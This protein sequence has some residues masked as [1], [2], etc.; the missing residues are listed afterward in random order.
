[1]MKN[2]S[3]RRF[4][5]GVAALSASPA[6]AQ[7]AVQLPVAGEI[8]VL[9]VGAGAAGI[10][11]ARR[12]VAAGRTYT[13]FEAR[14]RIGGRVWTDRGAFGIAH[15]RGAHRI[16]ASGRN[17]LVALGRLGGVDFYEPAPF[18]RLYVGPREARDHE[19]D[20]F[21]AALHRAS[22]AIAAAGEAGLDLAAVRTLPELGD[23][24][25]TVAFVLGPLATSK[26]L[27]EVSTVDFARADEQ[28]DTLACRGGLG[29]LLAA[30]AKPL[31]IELDTA[32]TRIDARG[33][34]AVIVET[35]RGAMRAN[36]V[37]VTASTAAVLSGAIRFEP[38]L[39]K[40]TVDAFAGLTLGTHDR[41]IFELP[42]NPFQFRDDQR[43]VF[44]AGD[45]RTLSLV[46]RVGGSDLAY[47]E[48][49]GR[50]GREMSDAGDAA[51]VEFVGEQFAAHFG[52]DAKKRIARSQ[53]TRWSREPW[54]LGAASVAA[55]GSGGNRRILA[56]PAHER[57]FFAGEALHESWYGTVAGAWIAGERAADAAIRRLV[58]SAPPAARV[59]PQQKQ[60]AK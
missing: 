29:V 53:V 2:L 35:P 14:S 21:T 44:K 26:D 17:P 7:P 8:D 18:R 41:L 15:D 47:A 43:V 25:A 23:W 39:P 46:G 52:A 3:R 19:Y 54:I 13:L 5:T 36:A 40:R 10:A 56:E 6:F 22:R 58:A 51:M 27:E 9:I 24:R 55:P 37:I 34:G 20:S 48:F 32:V 30:A 45:T 12:V 38:A 59:G 57:I 49:V 4:L 42:G 50:F 28:R 11:A 1:M 33:R 31:K 60:R 16:S